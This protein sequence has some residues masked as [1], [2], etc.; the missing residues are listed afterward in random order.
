MTQFI[1]FLK[2]LIDMIWQIKAV[3][4]IMVIMSFVLLFKSLKR[5][6]VD[7]I[8]II[9]F[10]LMFQSVVSLL[11]NLSNNNMIAFIKVFSNLIMIL[12]GRDNYEKNKEISNLLC[13]SFVLVLITNVI[14]IALGKGQIQWGNSLTLKG[15][16]YFKTDFA[17]AIMQIFIFFRYIPDK[18]KFIRRIIM[19]FICPVL[20]LLSNA[21]VY[22]IVIIIELACSYVEYLET[23]NKINKF[24]ID[25][26]TIAIGVIFVY[27]GI[28]MVSELGKTELFKSLNL[29]SF[30]MNA[31]DGGLMSESNTQGR[32]VI[33]EG[34]LNGISNEP[35]INKVLGI[36]Y[37]SDKTMNDKFAD[38]HNTYLKILF[39]FGYLGCILFGILIFVSMMYVNR[40]E[41]KKLKFTYIMLL[42]SYIVS[43]ISYSSIVF[44]Q[45]SW[46]FFLYLGMIVRYK[47]ENNGGS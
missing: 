41:N 20:I 21:R 4:L 17:L 36:D 9:V 25:I 43:G 12:I 27:S 30:D 42:V 34:I 24:K 16:Y 8:N 7:F 38:S 26:K 22:L 14:I 44:T 23:N 35:V 19:Y 39:S 40:E 37:V 31:K 1:I 45:Q 46:I 3:T 5:V 10:W 11:N 29:I 2:P 33:W 13:K 32:D 47:N 15:I 28:L 6:K 18:Y